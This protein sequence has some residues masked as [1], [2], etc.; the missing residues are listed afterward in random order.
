M[1]KLSAFS[2]EVSHDLDTQLRFLQDNNVGAMEIRFVDGR[3]IV[4]HS[5]ASIKAIHDKLQDHGIEVSAIGTPIGKIRLDEP[6]EDHLDLFKKAMDVAHTL[7]TPNLRIFSYY[8]PEGSVIDSFSNEVLDRM[9]QQINLM[10]GSGLRLVHEN[11][12]HI[13]GHSA[14]NCAHLASELDAAYFTLAYDPANFVWGEGIVTPMESCWSVMKSHVQHIHIKDWTKGDRLGSLP[15]EGDGQIHQLIRALTEDDYAGFM[16]ME[17]HLSKGG[18]F[19]GETDA[20]DFSR[21]I[22]LV[23]KMAGDVNMELA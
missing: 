16:T 2:D 21:S 4:Y 3:N 15:G 14:E 19:G 23:R 20:A 22:E 8:A 10:I 6:F 5:D 18:Q 9:H 1:V 7:G 13:Y 12:A 11:E 17:P